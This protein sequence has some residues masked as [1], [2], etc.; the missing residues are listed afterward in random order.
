MRIF[1]AISAVKSFS[2]N[3]LTITAFIIVMEMVDGHAMVLS[4]MAAAL[5]ASLVSRW[6]SRPLYTALSQFQLRRLPP[7]PMPAA[8]VHPVNAEVST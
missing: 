5:G 7:A 4:L 1:F 3:K 2:G 6:I 8:T